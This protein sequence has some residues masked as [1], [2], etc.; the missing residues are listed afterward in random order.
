MR[1]PKT[2]EKVVGRL[3]MFFDFVG[4]P[5]GAMK[6]RCKTF[7]EKGRK[8]NGWI[9][10]NLVAYLQYHK[11]RVEKKQISAGQRRNSQELLPGGQTIL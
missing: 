3:R 10:T 11:D 2:K 6:E 1:S 8:D 4:I 5:E 9:F 7:V